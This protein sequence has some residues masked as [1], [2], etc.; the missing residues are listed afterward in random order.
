LQNEL[1]AAK[2]AQASVQGELDT[3]V[4]ARASLQSDLDAARAASAELQ[5]EVDAAAALRADLDA[6]AAKAASLQSELDA[7]KA[8]EAGL[9]SDL[10]GAKTA[11]ASL[12]ADLDAA[13]AARAALQRDA[14][15]A[16]SLRSELDAANASRSAL[17]ADVDAAAQLRSQL[18]AARQAQAS[19]ESDLNALRGEHNSC[20][21]EHKSLQAQLDAAKAALAAQQQEAATATAS[22]D[23]VARMQR[24][25][26]A[27]QSRI[28]ELEQ[29]LAAQESAAAK[30]KADADRAAAAA[31]AEADKAAAAAAA[32]KAAE[33][34]SSLAAL[35]T[36]AWK[37]GTT[38]L[39]TPGANHKDD[40][41]EISGIGPKME[42]LLNSFGIQSWEQLAALD[43]S[44]VATVDGALE[45]FPG[46]IQ[47]DE[48]VEQAQAFI[49][50]G[51]KPVERAPRVRKDK[52]GRT[53]V[54]EW[55]KGQTKLGTPG[56]GHKDDLKV[57]NGIGPKMESI[58]N[59]F[60]ITC[61]EQLAAFKKADIE[62]VTDAIDAFPGRIERDEWVPQAKD[63]VKRFPLTDPYHRPTRETYLNN[64]A[65]DNP[66]E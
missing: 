48:W 51:H 46:R 63:L 8:A 31:K 14:E 38:K 47:R 15:A 34:V 25:L 7:A 36:G 32:A 3:A 21:D 16:A 43:A 45:E 29:K 18:E 6:S 37:Q 42:D 40:L 19:V 20:G 1:D 39:G 57:I 62:K 50:N 27:R 24:E 33:P 13:A 4:T 12:R 28:R 64:S 59:S 61:W 30:A 41:K 54:S 11:E 44:E 66:W 10:D 49:K 35:K 23:D 53:I 17:Q 55:S 2:A 60:G 58:L 52:S 5:S 56:A 9:R 26:D 22:A 65:D